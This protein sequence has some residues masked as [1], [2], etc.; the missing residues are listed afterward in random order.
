VFAPFFTT[1][2]DGMGMGLSISRRIVESHGGSIRA[3][4]NPDAGATFFFSLPSEAAN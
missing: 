2:C 4:N 1:K 3:R